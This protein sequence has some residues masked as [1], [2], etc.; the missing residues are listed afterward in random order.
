MNFRLPSW[1]RITLKSILATIIFLLAIFLKPWFTAPDI[2]I[3]QN[4][5][6]LPSTD[7]PVGH[8]IK[9][10]TPTPPKLSFDKLQSFVS[11]YFWENR[12]ISPPF[13]E[14]DIYQLFPHLKAQV[15]FP[16]SLTQEQRVAYLASV[17]YLQGFLWSNMSWYNQ[18]LPYK[19]FFF[20]Q[21]SSL[22][23]LS[24]EQ[25]M[26]IYLDNISSNAEYREV[27]THE[28]GHVV[29]LGVLKGK[30]KQKN[31]IFTEFG[32]IKFASDDPSLKFY[33]IS[34]RW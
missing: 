13:E 10:S 34:R 21:P 17:A 11:A 29:D 6:I 15:S 27:L 7:Q 1:L 16:P 3:W 2:L 28:M 18:F 9:K 8:L 19:I 14:Q 4:N 31:K 33:Q 23:A 25:K 22:R 12:P 30:S 26:F 32:E 20:D 24:N 5:N